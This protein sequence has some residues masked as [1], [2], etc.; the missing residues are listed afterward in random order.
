MMLALLSAWKEI[1]QIAG[2]VLEIVGAVLMAKRYAN[3]PRDEFLRVLL[4]ALWSRN[5]KDVEAAEQIA[6]LT[7]EDTRQILRGL[8]LIALGFALQAVSNTATLIAK[9]ST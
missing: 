2:S 9:L 5:T 8:A 3:V 4:S 6:V 7:P 1:L